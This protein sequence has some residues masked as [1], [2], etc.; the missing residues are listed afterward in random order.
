MRSDKSEQ[1]GK[2]ENLQ[3][4]AKESRPEVLVDS[5]RH[6]TPEKLMIWLAGDS[7]AYQSQSQIFREAD[8]QFLNSGNN[9]Y[10]LM[11][12]QFG[13]EVPLL[14]EQQSKATSPSLNE[15]FSSYLSP[16]KYTPSY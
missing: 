10:S 13:R 11:G 15:N 2:A 12:R 1:L 8:F 7:R 6:D 3:N 9:C 14:S 5:L 4:G 16:S